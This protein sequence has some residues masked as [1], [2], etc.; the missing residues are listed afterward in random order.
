MSCSQLSRVE[1]ESHS[2]KEGARRVA[3]SGR[4]DAGGREECEELLTSQQSEANV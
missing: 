2:E 1:L 4:S 3:H